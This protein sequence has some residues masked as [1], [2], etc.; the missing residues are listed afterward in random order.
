MKL[1]F[2]TLPHLQI[3]QNWGNV[4]PA[5]YAN[6]RHMGIDIAGMVG[7]AIYAACPGIVAEVNTINM[8]GY[9]RHVIIEH[10]DFK[11][12]YAHLHT[13]KV[14]QGQAVEAGEV[15]GTMGGDPL[16]NDPIDG[17]SSG[18]HLH[19]E[20]ILR[21][22]PQSDTI[23]TFAGY[24]VDP[25]EYLLKRFGEKTVKLGTV[26]ESSGVRVRLLPDT[27]KGAIVL[28]ALKRYDEISIVEMKETGSD[29]WVRILSLRAEWACA[30]YQG[31]KY[32]TLRDAPEPVEVET[33]EPSAESTADEKAIRLD[34][35]KRLLAILEVRKNELI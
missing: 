32:I 13:I 28:G 20:V 30:I 35:V 34:E 7:S 25:F 27:S 29:L 21:S 9:G 23:A 4:N 26:I 5:L 18:P 2:P 17:A 8:H 16:D 10:G 14:S 19:F 33:S 11:T 1:A 31:R 3:S 6:G 24:T 15:I 22:A 12:L